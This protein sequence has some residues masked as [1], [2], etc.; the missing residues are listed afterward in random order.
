MPVRSRQRPKKRQ[1]CPDQSQASLCRFRD[2]LRSLGY[3][4]NTT[5]QYVAL[6]RRFR[7]WLQRPRKRKLLIGEE[8]VAAFIRRCKVTGHLRHV[9]HI[10]CGLRHVL[11]MLRGCGELADPPTP[12]CTALDVAIRDFA[13]HLRETCGLAGTT[14][15]FHLYYVR[16]FLERKYGIG[17]LR[18]NCLC[19]DDLV[20]FVASFAQQWTAGSARR[21]ASSLRKYLRY[22]QLQ[23]ICDGQLV[24]SVPTIRQYR[25]SHL[26]RM[27]TEDQLRTFLSSFDR[28][29]PYGRRNYAMALLMSSL[30][31]RV[32]EVVL[33]Q[34]GDLNWRDG[35]IRIVCPKTRRMRMLPLPDHVGQAIADY[36]RHGRPAT[37][38]RW[39]F[40]RHI[41]PPGMAL[42]APAIQRAMVRAYRHCGFDPRWNGTHLL[43]H[44]MAT[45]LHQRGATLKEVADLLGH[46]SIESSAVYTK[47]NHPALTAVALPWPE[48]VS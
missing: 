30:G 20:S 27:M 46:R 21:L 6:F 4:A 22:L 37:A 44:T 34:L 8:S 13:L 16:Q 47:V 32:G 40:A 19:R 42:T 38:H 25:L 9:H 1:L 33:L 14:C 15:R 35:S 43:R 31:L 18:L 36:L 17:P 7:S 28:S 45:Q 11:R 29:T 12:P 24:A 3:A 26:P 10:Q 5:E 41:A 2:Y 23:G 39:V 48:V